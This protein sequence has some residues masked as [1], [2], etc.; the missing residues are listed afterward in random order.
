MWLRGCGDAKLYELWKIGWQ[1][2]TN[3]HLPYEQAFPQVKEDMSLPKDLHSML[4]AALL[5]MAQITASPRAHIQ[6]MNKVWYI[7]TTEYT[8]LEKWTHFR[9]VQ[10]PG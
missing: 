3:I 9:N 6:L 5:T 10:G 7:H 8:Q 2:L 1:F 4:T